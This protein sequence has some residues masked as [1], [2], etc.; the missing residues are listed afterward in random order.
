MIKY[1]RWS[2][3]Q[4]DYQKQSPYKKEGPPLGAFPL[5]LH[6]LLLVCFINISVLT[7]MYATAPNDALILPA[8]H[9]LRQKLQRPLLFPLGPSDLTIPWLSQRLRQDDLLWL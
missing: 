3:F 9:R 6:F 1:F 2:L 8:R 5:P 4:A 7:N